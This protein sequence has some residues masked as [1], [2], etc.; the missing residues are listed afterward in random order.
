MIEPQEGS[1]CLDELDTFAPGES[2]A[3]VHWGQVLCG[4]VSA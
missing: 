3:G 1:M 2:A 4:A